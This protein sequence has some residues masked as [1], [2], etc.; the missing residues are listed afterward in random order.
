MV[1]HKAVGSPF[2]QVSLKCYSIFSGDR[3]DA[4]FVWESLC[5]PGMQIC[6]RLIERVPMHFLVFP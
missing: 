6:Q 5:N 3:D 2:Y 4:I 1:V